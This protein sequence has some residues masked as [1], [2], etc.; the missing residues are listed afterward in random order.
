MGKPSDLVSRVKRA[1]SPAPAPTPE[2]QLAHRPWSAPDAV[3]SE[4]DQRRSG[5]AALSRSQLYTGPTREQLIEE[6]NRA[7]AI[8]AAMQ[9]QQQ[10]RR[11]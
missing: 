11:G 1:I 2:A 7:N 10:G 3:E 5:A 8:A 4:G 6:T 9:A